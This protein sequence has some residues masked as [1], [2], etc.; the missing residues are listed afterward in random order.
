MMG[1]KKTREEILESDIILFLGENNSDLELLKNVVKDK[2]Y[3]KILSKSDVN[4]SNRYDVN[5]CSLNGDGMADLLTLLS[6]KI[7]AVSNTKNISAEYYINK[8]QQDAINNLI[9]AGKNILSQIK[10]NVSHDI[11]ADLLHGFID[12]LNEIVDPINKEDIINE[13]FSTFCVGK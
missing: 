1:I 9:A 11:I 10:N 12:V 6:T 2:K 5:V 3:I 13:I 7:H 4:K 8:R